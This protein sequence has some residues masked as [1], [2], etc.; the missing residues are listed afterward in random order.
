MCAATYADTGLSGVLGLSDFLRGSRMG[1]PAR[2]SCFS[3]SA[4]EVCVKHT[5]PTLVPTTCGSNP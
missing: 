3:M 1:Q 5:R 4:Y 2:M